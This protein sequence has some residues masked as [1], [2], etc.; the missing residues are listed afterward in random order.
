M[1]VRETAHAAY[2]NQ[3]A[4]CKGHRSMDAGVPHAGFLDAARK[5]VM[6][7]PSKFPDARK[8]I[9]YDGRFC[10]VQKHSRLGCALVSAGSMYL[11]DEALKFLLTRG[12]KD[13]MARMTVAGLE[14]TVQTHTDKSA[15]DEYQ[16]DS[17]FV[18]WGRAV[19]KQ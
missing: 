14:V 5:E 12:S 17:F 3:I 8:P 16:R 11:R 19:E 7:A 13:G 6:P 4:A 1:S 15:S 2:M 9:F 10:K 18:G